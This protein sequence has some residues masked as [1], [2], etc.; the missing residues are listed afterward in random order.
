[1]FYKWSAHLGVFAPFLSYLMF[2]RGMFFLN[3]MPHL[4]PGHPRCLPSSSGISFICLFICLLAVSGL[5]W[6]DVSCG[7]VVVARG[8]QCSWAS[9]VAA[10]GIL[11][12]QPE[13]EPVS[14]ALQGT[15]LNTGPPGKSCQWHFY[16]PL[17]HPKSFKSSAGR[18]G[19]EGQRCGHPWKKIWGFSWT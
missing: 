1:M 12:P 5:S 9:V 4:S 14:P 18:R 11:V 16:V 17:W 7:T 8:L 2:R 6:T 15:F 3:W 19:K 10:R 13:I